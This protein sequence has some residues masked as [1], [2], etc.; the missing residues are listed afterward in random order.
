[1]KKYVLA[2][3]VAA[4]LA[5]CDDGRI[6]DEEA[7]SASTGRSVTMKATIDGS[8]DYAD[9]SGYSVALAA[10]G[11]D[12]Y[13][14]VSKP[15]GDGEMEVTL[16][17]LPSAARTVEVCLI[18]RLRERLYTFASVDMD[19]VAAADMSFDA[20][21]IDVGMYATVA[22]GIFAARCAQCHGATGH[23]AAGL[24][25]V[26]DSSWG[27]LVGVPSVVVD[28]ASRVVP[29]DAG[30]STLWQAVATEV[31]S[32]WAF[33]HAALLTDRDKDF[34]KDWINSGAER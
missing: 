3:L 13:A 32:G 31:S 22:S 15:V 21:S 17:G 29:S 27:S 30:A 16:S 23:S 26:S 28:G 34:I 4:V 20:G 25:L 14:L 9:L 7:P 2:F 24:D 10:F 18:S 11:D 6:Y 12:D 19:E 1:M 8:A 5:S 33:N